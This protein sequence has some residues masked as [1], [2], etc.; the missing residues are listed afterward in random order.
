MLVKLL[1]NLLVVSQLWNKINP[2]A[3]HFG[4]AVRNYKGA[5]LEKKSHI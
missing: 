5:G 3:I 1:F 4:E 2:I